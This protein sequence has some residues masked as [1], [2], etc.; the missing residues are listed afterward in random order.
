MN[1]SDQLNIL[2]MVPLPADLLQQTWGKRNK[3]NEML[4]ER[5]VC[6]VAMIML[7]NC[8]YGSLNGDATT[9]VLEEDQT[10]KNKK[11]TVLS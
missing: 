4:R 6:G 9:F 8:E 5:S 1:V 3:G 7:V 2:S 11:V 10:I